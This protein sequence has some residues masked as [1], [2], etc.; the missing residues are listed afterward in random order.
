[1]LCGTF[2]E[3]VLKVDVFGFCVMCIDEGV[4]AKRATLT[5]RVGGM[6]RKALN[7]LETLSPPLF[8]S[9]TPTCD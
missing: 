1:M 6:S 9:L 7:L 2:V 3:K 4:R 5:I 8:R